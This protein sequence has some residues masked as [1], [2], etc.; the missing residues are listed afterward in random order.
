MS[1]GCSKGVVTVI[2][3]LGTRWRKVISFTLR[4]IWPRGKET[5]VRVEWD[6]G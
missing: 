2:P 4:Q 5:P 6:A 3:N 1:C